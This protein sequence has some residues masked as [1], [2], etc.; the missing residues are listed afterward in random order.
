M[1]KESSSALLLSIRRGK[2][3]EMAPKRRVDVSKDTRVRATYIE[4]D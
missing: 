2:T 1:E 4:N 3:P